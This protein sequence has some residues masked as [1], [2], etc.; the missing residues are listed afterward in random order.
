MDLALH[1]R[2]LSRY[3][4]FVLVGVLV[5][6]VLAFLAYVRVGPDGIGYRE[7]E[8][9]QSTARL[10]AS[11]G[12]DPFRAPTAQTP[13]A[14]PTTFAIL[15]AEFANSDAVIARLEQNG[16]MRGEVLATVNQVA[17][18]FVPFIDVAGIDAS[19]AAARNL[20]N[21]AAAAMKE[22]V[23]S[24]QGSTRPSRRVT[25]ELVNAP[26]DP[27]LVGG[28]SKTL[29]VMIFFAIVSLVVGTV[30]VREN[31]RASGA[32]AAQ[33]TEPGASISAL[34]PAE[35]AEH[36]ASI[37]ALEPAEGAKPGPRQAGVED[38]QRLQARSAQ[39][40]GSTLGTRVSQSGRGK[41]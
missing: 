34:E 36:G 3:R 17:G 10:F 18:D 20:A 30:Y 37:S 25:L 28:R 39:R 11:V 29:P 19:P 14:D 22:Y 16:Q 27:I 13:T 7:A 4:R 38:A 9:W 1:F 41:T 6:I 8:R 35:A 15:A 2:V 40:P 24:R 23:A 5:A 21:R 26:A 12:G 32:G 33:A 31:L